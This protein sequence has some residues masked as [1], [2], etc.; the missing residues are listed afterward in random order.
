MN[1]VVAQPEWICWACL[2]PQPAEAA[3]H[4]LLAKLEHKVLAAAAVPEPEQ[5]PPATPH[6]VE[7]A[8]PA[9]PPVDGSSARVSNDHEPS[10]C[11]VCAASGHVQR[12][13][14]G[15][16]M[17]S[18]E[19]SSQER[20]VTLYTPQGPQ[21]LVPDATLP[22]DV[23]VPVLPTDAGY[24][25]RLDAQ[26]AAKSQ[27]VRKVRA[28]PSTASQPPDTAETVRSLM[29]AAQQA[30]WAH[31]EGKTTAEQYG[32]ELLRVS[33]ELATVAKRVRRGEG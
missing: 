6:V 19:L 4:E 17:G 14:R 31:G 7:A 12:D 16:V 23:V 28:Q 30:L 3:G 10:R 5:T 8:M 18:P 1:D 15:R 13:A 9:D 29:R 22:R 21:V 20:G 2:R 11:D 33:N 26:L 27:G 32:V 24:E 25:Q